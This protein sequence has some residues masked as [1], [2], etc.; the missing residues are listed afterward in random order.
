[1]AVPPVAVPVAECR[2]QSL[3]PCHR[4]PAV[5]AA[6]GQRP[7]ALQTLTKQAAERRVRGVA[8]APLGVMGGGGDPV[9]LGAARRG[10]KTFGA[11]TAIQLCRRKR[12]S[13]TCQPKRWVR[14]ARIGEWHPASPMHQ[15]SSRVAQPCTMARL[16][17]GAHRAPRRTNDPGL[18][19]G[20]WQQ[21]PCPVSGKDGGCH[22]ADSARPCTDSSPKPSRSLAPK[23]ALQGARFSTL[24]T[25]VKRKSGSPVLCESAARSR[26]ASAVAE[27]QRASESNPLPGHA[28]R[29]AS[30]QIQSHHTQ[31][32]SEPWT[33]SLSSRLQCLPPPGCPV[34]PVQQV[35]HGTGECPASV[36]TPGGR[37]GPRGP[38]VGGT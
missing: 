7:G 35:L 11:V 4:E 6:L 20:P 18:W 12:D 23:P 30:T 27:S 36:Q 34:L 22:C 17:P 5:P 31:A 16:D 28:Q 25:K 38:G 37:L 26:P 1:M 3:S 24:P 29:Q 21:G 19:R 2:L 33:R 15:E 10:W 13:L 9:W 32:S 14:D 8:G